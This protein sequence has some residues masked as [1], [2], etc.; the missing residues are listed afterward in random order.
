MF[1][2][3]KVNYFS[4]ILQVL[5]Q[6]QQVWTRSVKIGQDQSRSIK[7]GQGYT[8]SDCPSKIG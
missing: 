1:C 8:T 3:N 4:V 6:D 5:G 2:E 7:I